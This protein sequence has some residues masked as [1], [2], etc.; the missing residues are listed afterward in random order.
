MTIASLRINQFRNLNSVQITPTQAGLNIISGDNGSGK[1]S[2]L[3]AIFYLGHG[4]SFRSSLASRMINHESDKFS[5][6]T[7]IV[8][9]LQ[10]IVPLGVE[11][12]QSGVTRLR[13][14]EN[15]AQGL[16]EVAGYLPI[17]VIN[18]QSHQM[19]EG[20][21]T[22]R[23]KYLDWGLFY[24]S[25]E[26]LQCWRQ[27]ERVLK[28]RN[29]ILRDKRPRNELDTWTNELIKHGL[30]LD[31]LRTVYLS[32]LLPHIRYFSNA[33]LA[34]PN[35]EIDYQQGWSKKRDYVTTL[36]ETIPEDYRV[37]YTQAGPHRADFEL[38]SEGLTLRHVLSR[39]QQ[40]LLICA[41]ILAQGMLLAEQE[42]TGLI[43]LVDDLPSELDLLSRQKLVSLLAMQKSQIFITAI[44]KDAIC[45]LVCDK[46]GVPMKVFH[47]EHGNVT[48]LTETMVQ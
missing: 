42:K 3:E 30:E 47:V 48:E 27:Y 5:L 40:K 8:T 31:R 34:M 18:S 4:K 10:R 33:L 45:D 43:Y 11:R 37:G 32:Q 44:E 7:H 16:A 26:F 21:P 39:G 15:D 36:L 17:R 12:E 1:T 22:F 41:M 46:A 35:I 19:L 38:I 29:T 2:L 13:L 9:S 14:D 25:T 23:R 6:F 20:G 28:Q 24:Q